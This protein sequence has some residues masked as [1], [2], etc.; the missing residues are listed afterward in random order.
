MNR[1]TITQLSGFD[2]A[3]GA[4]GANVGPR[5]GLDKRTQ[6]AKEWFV[7]RRF[8]S[9]ALRA[10]LFDFPI[11]ISKVTPPEPDFAITHGPAS[12]TAL[13]E[14]TEAT[15]PDDQREMT[16]FAESNKDSMLLGD[17][18]GR[19]ADGASQP[20]FAWASDILDAILRKQDKSICASNEHDRHLLV[21]P[22]SN[23]SQLLF[24]EADE[25][26]A[27]AHLRERAAQESLRY[28]EALNGC[29]VHVLG[30]MLVCV[31]LTGTHSLIS[32]PAS[33]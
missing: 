27:F 1:V 8:V 17:F 12:K 7:L 19:F 25:R 11:A 4:L 13:V 30:K 32:R 5:I 3:F 14:I 23:A 10:R 28:A 29:R 24:D 15:H 26:A 20:K 22:N 2:A 21:Y 9:A 16:K 33:E 31:D 18:G 6:D